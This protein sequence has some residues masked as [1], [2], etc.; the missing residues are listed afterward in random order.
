[1]TRE[2]IMITIIIVIIITAADEL[3]FQPALI[4]VTW[5]MKICRSDDGIQGSK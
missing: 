3:L 1:V 4:A 5:E 2:I